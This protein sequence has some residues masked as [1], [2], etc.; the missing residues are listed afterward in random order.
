MFWKETP[1]FV[2]MLEDE[3]KME[4][5][6]SMYFGASWCVRHW[7]QEENKVNMVSVLME[8]T[9]EQERVKQETVSSPN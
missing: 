5:D 1:Y 4:V 9:A 2:G 7:L 6:W 3:F 8:L